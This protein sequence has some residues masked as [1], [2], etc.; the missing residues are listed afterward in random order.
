MNSYLSQHQLISIQVG[1]KKS[2]AF[3]GT[4]E[5]GGWKFEAGLG[6]T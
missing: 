2:R 4:G 1:V 3:V 5:S 6:S